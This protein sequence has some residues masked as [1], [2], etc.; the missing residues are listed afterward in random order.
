MFPIN[1][2]LFVC[3]AFVFVAG[4]A[5]GVIKDMDVFVD[6]VVQVFFV[7][8]VFFM[9]VDIDVDC[10]ELSSVYHYIY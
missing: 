1:V 5:T 2:M 9:A 6:I 10:V 7:A 3:G 4:A 8:Y